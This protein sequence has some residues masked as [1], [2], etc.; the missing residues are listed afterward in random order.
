MGLRRL[1]GVA[2][3]LI[4]IGV[5]MI[6]S[7]DT[8]DHTLL[9][10][11]DTEANV[12]LAALC[13]GVAL[14]TA[15]TIVITRVRSLPVDARFRVSPSPSVPFTRRRLLFPVAATSPPSTTLRI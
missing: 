13:V 9:D 10:G 6:E 1:L 15:A 12:V 7:F 2:I 4:C 8:W 14:T 5:P 3:L 11:N